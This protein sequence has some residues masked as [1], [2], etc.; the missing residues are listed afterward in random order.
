M[1]L[2]HFLDNHKTSDK[3][4]HTHT[5]FNKG[6]VQK[7]HIP[8]DKLPMFWNMYIQER[9]LLSYI[10][11]TEKS[12][13]VVQFFADLDMD[14][15]ILQHI[16][17]VPLFIKHVIDTFNTVLQEAIESEFT[18][19]SA[20]RMIYKC[21]LF[22]S[23]VF[24][25]V[26][27]CTSICL[28][29]YSRLKVK[30]PWITDTRIIDTSVYSSGLRMLG[31]SKIGMCK[32]SLVFDGGYMV[33]AIDN[34]GILNC[35]TTLLFGDLVQS[36]I[37]V[38]KDA[39]KL[40][41][42]NTYNNITDKK[43]K[44]KRA[45][46]QQLDAKTI[47]KDITEKIKDYIFEC[48][49][50]LG[51][52][53]PDIVIVQSISSDCLRIDLPPQICPFTKKMH[54][55][56]SDRGISAHYI[57]LNAFD[58]NVRC[59]KCND[60]ALPLQQP[61]EEITSYLESWSPNYYLKSS[62]Y[63]QT[64][65]TISEYIFSLVKTQFAASATQ[66]NYTWYYYDTQLH[67]WIRSEKIT[68][69][70][71]NSKGF[72]QKKYE[73]YIQSLHAVVGGDEETNVQMSKALWKKLQT[74]LQTTHFV[75]G[76]ILPLVARK[77]EE[78]WAPFG[79]TSDS[80][81]AKLDCNPT[82]MAWNNG[83]YD[84]RTGIFRDGSPFDFISMTTGIDYVPYQSFGHEIK[85][86]LHTFLSSIFV[87][88]THLLY[89]LQQMA[90]SLNGVNKAQSF[91]ILTGAGANGKS[92]LVKLLNL[93]LG[94]YAG[95]VNVTLFTHNRPPA[96]AP[97]PEL[98]QIKGKRFVT[99]S[100]PNG[101]ETFNL[102]TVKWL[103]GGDRITAAA[104]FENNQSFYLQCTFFLL[105]NDIPQINAG[106]H[107]FGTWRRM[108]PICF[109]SR[110]VEVDNGDA[111]TRDKIFVADPN[112]NTKLE[113]WKQLFM[114]LLIHT[115]DNL[116]DSIPLEMP[117]EFKLLWRQ[118]QNK[119]DLYSRF[120]QEHVTRNSETF[121]D[122]QSVFIIFCSW[123]KNMRLSKRVTYDVFEKHMLLILGDFENEG[124]GGGKK[125]W[126]IDVKNVPFGGF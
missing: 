84:C 65:E 80:F 13:S 58:C 82:L 98:I 17:D 92:T 57:L 39:Q 109:N 52:V 123:V 91:F 117:T 4:S 45:A 85:E 40:D 111:V 94:D 122:A 88:K 25:D 102:G 64:H 101:R 76:G 44:R 118:L 30:Y 110:F 105:T 115:L 24:L 26:D 41:F 79:S 119:N 50:I 87:D 74:S 21:H 56:S 77:L 19:T 7:L 6:Y 120:I 103:T 54:K 70:I 104:K 62:L 60:Q 59:W 112:I 49:K 3:E 83:V 12:K 72:I 38:P 48:V 11:I 8:K 66:T 37:I 29:V 113:L 71:M 93:G 63:N 53:S 43:L 90:L 27:Q 10:C 16:E 81:Q 47:D 114:A 86:E 116:K 20:Y 96:N 95:E 124:D 69:F 61:C 46:S 89:S 42:K 22:F 15:T 9:P 126:F 68:A 28:D 97:T 125:G 67:R 73:A 121:R 1:A 14:E 33:G 2:L 108:K 100:E 107:D 5:L 99:C 75:R 78:Y 106:N 31:C 35:K 51:L 34:N 32:K 55:R 18:I 23:G 36:S